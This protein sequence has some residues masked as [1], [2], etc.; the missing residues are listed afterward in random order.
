MKFNIS[1]NKEL[2][3]KAIREFYQE[4][5][6]VILES[7]PEIKSERDIPKVIGNE[8]GPQMDAKIAELAGAGDTLNKIADAIRKLIGEPWEPIEEINIYV[9]ACP[10][11][12]RFLET[13][14]FLLP[15]YYELPVLLNWSA[16]E[17]IHFLY[18]KKWAKLFPNDTVANFESPDPVWVLSEILVATI[19]NDPIIQ[20]VTNTE[21]NIYPDWDEMEINSEK[22]VDIFQKIYDKSETFDEFLK[23]SWVKYQELDKANNLTKKLTN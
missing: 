19:G 6:P 18:F 4:K 13:N 12:P 10:I 9:G 5:D 15:Y 7:W 17:M 21:F 14:S 16:H 1:K 8:Y 3:L 20:K 23:E 2:D 22:L 11:A